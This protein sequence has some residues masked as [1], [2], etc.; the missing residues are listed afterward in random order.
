VLQYSIDFLDKIAPCLSSFRPFPIIPV[1]RNSVS[2]D[3]LM[4]Q[5]GFWEID[6][7]GDTVVFAVLRQMARRSSAALEAYVRATENFLILFA[8]FQFDSPNIS[9]YFSSLNEIETCLINLQITFEAMN[10]SHNGNSTWISGSDIEACI[11]LSN[12]I[13][14]FGERRGRGRV[15]SNFPVW[16]ETG[17]VTDGIDRVKISTLAEIVV[18]VEDEVRRVVTFDRG[19]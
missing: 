6:A 9:A 8:D 3:A 2:L 16:L 11:R 10:K 7:K 12:S 18:S 14:H 13:K 15:A 4:L 17:V 19:L 1:Q 5:I